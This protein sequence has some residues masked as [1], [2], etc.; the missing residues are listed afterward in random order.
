ML[1]QMCTAAMSYVQES[2][3]LRWNLVSMPRDIFTNITQELP[4]PTAIQELISIRYVSH[5]RRK[6][7]S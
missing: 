6:E 2:E 7:P 3:R 5:Q 4:S 1:G